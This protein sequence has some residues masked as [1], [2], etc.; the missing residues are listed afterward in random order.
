MP[1]DTTRD[2]TIVTVEEGRVRHAARPG[3]LAAVLVLG[4]VPLLASYRES[5]TDPASGDPADPSVLPPNRN[6]DDRV[7]RKPGQLPTP[8][9]QYELR[10][11]ASGPAGWI[12]LGSAANPY[13]PLG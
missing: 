3:L 11:V 4:A 10:N 5:C 8:F 12:I 7:N 1:S 13:R 2:R 9:T 6:S